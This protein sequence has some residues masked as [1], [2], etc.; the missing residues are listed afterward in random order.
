MITP[1]Q[2]PVEAA[3]WEFIGNPRFSDAAIDALA[4]LALDLVEAEDADNE[5][6]GD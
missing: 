1:A 6:T 5:H 3:E 2:N 4:E